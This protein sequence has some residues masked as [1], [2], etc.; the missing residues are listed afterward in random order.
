MFNTVK[1]FE[2]G[3]AV[4]ALNLIILVCRFSTPRFLKRLTLESI[5]LLT[6]TRSSKRNLAMFSKPVGV[7]NHLNYSKTSRQASVIC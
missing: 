2:I 6:S 7:G 1:K 4:F 5:E 3:N